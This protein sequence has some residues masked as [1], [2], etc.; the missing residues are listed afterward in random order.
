VIGL[1]PESTKST[2]QV[3]SEG[4]AQLNAPLWGYRETITS[5]DGRKETSVEVQITPVL[6]IFTVLG[7][8]I[9]IVLKRT[10]D[11]A[12]DAYHTVV[13]TANDVEQKLSG[14]GMIG[15]ILTWGPWAGLK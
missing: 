12:E 5:K 7:V 10:I 1:D 11:V 9:A 6:I 8:T 13:K 15:K 2:A 3:V 4:I 14:L